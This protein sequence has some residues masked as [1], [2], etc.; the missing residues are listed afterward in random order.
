MTSVIQ[1]H[2][3]LVACVHVIQREARADALAREGEHT[4]A[5]TRGVRDYVGN[6]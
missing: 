1:F 6:T 4:P 3:D 5:F 2:P